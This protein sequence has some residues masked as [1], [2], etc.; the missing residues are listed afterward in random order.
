VISIVRS[1]Q[2]YFLPQLRTK[3]ANE[4]LAVLCHQELCQRLFLPTEQYWEYEQ[5]NASVVQPH[6]RQVNPYHLGITILRE[7]SGSPPSP[8][9]RSAS[10]GR[11]RA[12]W[13][14]LSRF[15]RFAAHTTTRRCCASS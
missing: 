1:E 14:R 4:G 8:T 10:A 3:I 2:A 11:G 5:L 7:I 13:S 15:A 9:T 12:R 6:H